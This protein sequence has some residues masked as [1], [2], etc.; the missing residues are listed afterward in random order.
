MCRSP[1][2][3]L[4][5]SR[6]TRRGMF[7]F[8]LL[9][10]N[11]VFGSVFIRVALSEGEFTRR[12]VVRCVVLGAGVRGISVVGLFLG[13]SSRTLLSGSGQGWGLLRE[14]RSCTVEGR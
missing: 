6:M 1:N 2:F 12:F 14:K 10:R 3:I 4:P 9:V 7:M 5:G 13:G 8:V 11:W